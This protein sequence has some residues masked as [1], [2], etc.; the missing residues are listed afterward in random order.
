MKRKAP[1]R[2]ITSHPFSLLIKPASADCNLACEYCF[3]L[4]KA[5][6]YPEQNVHRMSDE[7]LERLVRSYMETDQPVYSF[8]WQ[9]GEPTLMGAD[10]FRKVTDYQQRYGKPGARVANGLQTN[11]TLVD[12]ELAGHLGEYQFLVGVSI[13][14]PAELHDAYRRTRADKPSHHL[15]MRGVERLR[16]HNVEVNVLVLVSQANVRHAQEVYRYLKGEGFTYMQFIPC[17]EFMPDGSAS[18]FSITGPEWGAFLNGIYD[19][20]YPNDVRTVSVRHH[21]ALVAFFLDGSR[22]M[23]TMGGKCDAYFVVEHNG[24][25]YP[26][27]F[28][29]EPDL[30][31]GNVATDDWATLE[32]RPVR[33]KFAVRKAS[34]IEACTSC[35]HLPYCSGD[36]IKHREHAPDGDGSWLCAG[37]RAFYDYAVPSL[38]E[39]AAEVG[40]ERGAAGPLWNPSAWDPDAPCYCG[41]GKKARN[42]HLRV[43][44]VRQSA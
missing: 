4:K 21:D 33:N 10:F 22:H 42:C 12:D 8:G 6:L 25:I 23:C 29:V 16:R 34:W 31:V 2:R 17:V 13:D 20:W 30:K 14:G 28:F 18:D 44:F 32:R 24:D 1:T 9:G 43:R 35:P 15:A 40:A 7:V 3:Y 38:R 27:D 19:E 11:A 36:C 5:G 41:S 37:W 39:L 26:C